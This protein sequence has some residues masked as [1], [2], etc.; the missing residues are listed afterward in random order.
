[1][2]RREVITLLGGTAAASWSM[3]ARAQPPAPA[4]RR[5]GVLMNLDE[6]DR[7]GEARLA[8]FVERLQQLGWSNGRNLTRNPAR[9]NQAAWSPDGRALAFTSDRD[10][11]AEIY[12]MNADGRQQ[13]N[14]TRTRGRH[15]RWLAWSLAQK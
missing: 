15:E 4:T 9:D 2:R 14:L 1:M 5:I 6:A 8:A 7:V 11:N 10:G 12:V 13:R 3:A